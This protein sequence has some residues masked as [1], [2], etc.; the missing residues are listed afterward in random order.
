M[1]FEKAFWEMIFG[2]VDVLPMYGFLKTY[3]MM[4]TNMKDYVTLNFDDTDADFRYGYRDTMIAQFKKDLYNKNF[5]LQD[6]DKRDNSLQKRIR[7]WL[8]YVVVNEGA[9]VP[10]NVMIMNITMM[11]W[12]ISFGGQRTIPNLEN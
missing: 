5:S 10:D 4:V 9:P 12:L 1:V 11:D 6:Q 7:F 8:N 2:G 3:I